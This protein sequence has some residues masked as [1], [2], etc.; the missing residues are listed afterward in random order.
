MRRLARISQ[1]RKAHVET[2]HLEVV[3][4]R[5]G[6]GRRTPGDENPEARILEHERQSFFWIGRVEGN[7]GGARFKNGKKAHHELEGALEA[8]PHK[9]TGARPELPKAP[10]ERARAPLELAVREPAIPVLHGDRV[11]R[12]AGL[13]PNQLVEGFLARVLPRRRIPIAKK[14]AG[15]VLGQ[16][17]NPRHRP[18][19]IRRDPLEQRFEAGGH[20]RDRRFLEDVGRVFEHELDPVLLHD[21]EQSEVELRGRVGQLE[22]LDGEPLDRQR[23]AGRVVELEHDLKQR[24]MGETPFRTQLLDELLEGEVLVLEGLKCDVTS[25][26]QQH[27]KRR[28]VREV[29]AQDERIYEEPDETL[30]LE[31]VAPGNGRSNR[32]VLLTTEAADENLKRC[33]K[34][35]EECGV[36]LSGQG[37]ESRRELRRQPAAYV[38]A[39]EGSPWRARPIGRQIENRQFAREMLLPERELAG[40]PLTL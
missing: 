37:L 2:H 9:D 32:N 17:R 19:W 25:P 24:G 12:P 11:R 23:F 18:R 36:L 15:L 39:P 3:P 10:R 29:P 34:G 20:T 13:L 16:E 28:I 14:Q 26:R 1:D 38:R 33:E 35:H 8:D 22:R 30:R 4:Q 31:T 7:V 21:R 40:K 5:E 6:F 27:R